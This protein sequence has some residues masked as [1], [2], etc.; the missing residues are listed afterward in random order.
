MLP[1]TAEARATWTMGVRPPGRIQPIRNAAS[2]ATATIAPTISATGRRLGGEA[3]SGRSIRRRERS[4]GVVLIA[5]GGY[6][7]RERGNVSGERAVGQGGRGRS[8][9]PGDG[10]RAG[11]RGLSTSWIAAPYRGGRSVVHQ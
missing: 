8:A 5:G 1:P 3:G 4:G 11:S 10:R 9:R 7:G 2:S 6:E